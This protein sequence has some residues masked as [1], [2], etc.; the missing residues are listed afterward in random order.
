MSVFDEK[1]I[2]YCPLCGARIIEND[3]VMLSNG[4]ICGVCFDRFKAADGDDD[5]AHMSVREVRNIID[6]EASATSVRSDEGD[7][8]EG[9]DSSMVTVTDDLCPVCGLLL[10]GKVHRIADAVICQDCERMERSMYYKTYAYWDPE[11]KELIDV[12]INDLKKSGREKDFTV[13]V[14]DELNT[15]TLATVKEDY[16]LF[17]QRMQD[18]IR[19]APSH[20]SAV[21]YVDDSFS[22]GSKTVALVGVAKGSFGEGDEV[23]LVHDGELASADVIIAYSAEGNSYEHYRSGVVSSTLS[24]GEFGWLVFKDI[25]PIYSLTD[26]IYIL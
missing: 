1:E 9:S 4:A 2:N 12:D 20:A 8:S 3:A 22:D 16:I 7:A 18:A 26:I 17:K 5:I 11:G 6:A 19:S 15:V 10:R 13:E 14:K 23:I 24:S 25:D 21:A